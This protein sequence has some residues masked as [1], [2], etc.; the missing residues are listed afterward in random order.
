MVAMRRPPTVAFRAFHLEL[1]GHSESPGNARHDELEAEEGDAWY[2][3]KA[4][5]ENIFIQFILS[6]DRQD[7]AS[8]NWAN[9]KKERK[10]RG[11]YALCYNTRDIVFLHAW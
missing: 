2:K 10:A 5:T 7:F 6:K 8:K 1:V 11:T 3:I 4:Q 9:E